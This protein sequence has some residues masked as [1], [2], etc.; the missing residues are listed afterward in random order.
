MSNPI[1]FLAVLD[2]AGSMTFALGAIPIFAILQH[3][4]VRTWAVF[5][6]C[7]FFSFVGVGASF[8]ILQSAIFGFK[9]WGISLIIAIAMISLSYGQKYAKV[10]SRNSFTP[11]DLISYI[12]QGFL[13][14]TTWPT[15]AKAVGVESSI[16]A[17]ATPAKVGENIFYIITFFFS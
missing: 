10:E 16:T 8:L 15:L 4:T 12:I 11:V 7:W 6:L 3:E 13:W 9:F 1:P 17:P 2:L 5:I 14:P